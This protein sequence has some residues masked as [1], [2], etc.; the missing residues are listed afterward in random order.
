MKRSAKILFI[1]AV[2]SFASA[3]VYGQS[4]DEIISKHIK[5]HGG[6]E[7]WEKVESMKITGYFTAFSERNPITEIKARGDKYFADFTLGQHKVTE[8]CDGKTYWTNN[9]WFDLPFARKMNSNEIMV[10]KQNAEFCTPFFNYK[11]RG[12]Q[13]KYEGKDKVEDIEVFKL[14]LT[15]ESGQVETWYLRTDSYLEYMNKSAWGDF[16]TPVDQEAVYDDFRKVG[17]ITLPFYIERIF[18]SRNSVTEIENVELN[19]SLEPSVFEIPLSAPMQKLQFLEGNWNVTVDVMNRSGAMVN[20][21]STTSVIQ[22]LKDKNILQE[23]ISYVRYFPVEKT[24]TW[25]YN[26]ELKN[27]RLCVFNDIY[28]NTDLFQGNF[29]NDSLVMDNSEISFGKQGITTPLSKYIFSKISN[30]G[31]LLETTGSRDGGT[32]WRVQQRF[33]Y[34]RKM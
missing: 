30:N 6:M 15:R 26:T 7:A 33:T 24:L 5:A 16:A 32:T 14:L 27:Y 20:A 25:T 1:L 22:F 4:V 17:D 10:T 9:P 13:V 28:S 23:T 12:F 8:G 2:F 21:D 18:D 29:T 31:F 3:F 11:K 34:L 19:L